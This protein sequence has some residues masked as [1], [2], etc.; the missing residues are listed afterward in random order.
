MHS[1]IDLEE[2]TARM[3][4][5]HVVLRY[6]LE[7]NPQIEQKLLKD[8]EF[9]ESGMLFLATSDAWHE[10]FVRAW[11]EVLPPSASPIPDSPPQ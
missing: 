11:D 1:H 7:A 6:L 10:K 4:V 2:I 3:A 8:R 9:L 5:Q